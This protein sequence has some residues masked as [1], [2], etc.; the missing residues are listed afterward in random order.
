MRKDP[1]PWSKRGD[2]S[3]FHPRQ[4]INLPSEAWIWEQP[5]QIEIDVST[6]NYD[7]EVQKL[8]KS[9]LNF[10]PIRIVLI[11]SM[12]SYWLNDFCSTVL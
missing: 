11:L 3:S 1:E 10:L 2:H 12:F 8:L 6:E 5:W 9:K 4:A 7:K